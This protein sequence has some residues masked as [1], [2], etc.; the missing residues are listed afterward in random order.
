[1]HIECTLR[2]YAHKQLQMGDGPILVVRL[3]KRVGFDSKDLVI[4]LAVVR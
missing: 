4:E 2:R 3:L 1:M